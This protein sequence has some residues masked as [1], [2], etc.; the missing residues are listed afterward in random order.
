MSDSEVTTDPLST[1]DLDALAAKLADKL[2]SPTP[3]ADYQ[4]LGFTIIGSELKATVRTPSGDVYQGA[5]T[6]WKKVV[7]VEVKK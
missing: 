6:D 5:V 4:L 3:T 2:K 1:V 7:V